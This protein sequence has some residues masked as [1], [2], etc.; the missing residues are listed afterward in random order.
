M[1]PGKHMVSQD[2][3]VRGENQPSG[4]QNMSDF[5]LERTKFMEQ[6]DILQHRITHLQSTREIEKDEY[7]RELQNRD[8]QALLLQSGHEIDLD[9]LRAKLAVQVAANEMGV[10][11]N[12]QLQANLAAADEQRS[13]NRG[14][15]SSHAGPGGAPTSCESQLPRRLRRPPLHETGPLCT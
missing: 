2:T 5:V 13:T 7:R 15:P 3:I 1:R 10:L 8:G 12:A 14:R 6:I 9:D 11:Q 4:T